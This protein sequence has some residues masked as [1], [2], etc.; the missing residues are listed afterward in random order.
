MET[1]RQKIVEDRVK[2]QKLPLT[3]A[4]VHTYCQVLKRLHKSL[5]AEAELWQTD[6]WVCDAEKI[7]DAV[8]SSTTSKYHQVLT[9]NTVA[10]ICPRL[11]EPLMECRAGL[12]ECIDNQVI[13]NEC[14]DPKYKSWQE[15]EF[16]HDNEVTDK[17][18]EGDITMKEHLNALCFLLYT[19]GMPPPRLDLGE[20]MLGGTP[21]KRTVC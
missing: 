9:L 12:Q 1:L 21:L 18:Y 16:M 15:L 5:G 19:S 13:E 17:L 3:S 14:N 7:R 20:V 2:N 11:A 8:V 4:S 10:S 6:V